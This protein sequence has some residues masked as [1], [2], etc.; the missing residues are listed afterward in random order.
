M[1]DRSTVERLGIPWIKARGGEFGTY[2]SPGEGYRP[3]LGVT[4]EVMI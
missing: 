4:R 3:Y 2:S 1:L